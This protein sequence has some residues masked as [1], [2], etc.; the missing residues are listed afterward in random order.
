MLFQLW[1]NLLNNALKYSAKKEFPEIEIG[2][3]QKNGREV[4]YVSD[5]GVGIEEKYFE[6]IFESFT[7]VAGKGYK[8]S[9]IGLA[10]VKKIIDKHEG[11]IWVESTLKQGTTFYFYTLPGE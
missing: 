7:R 3:A 4:Y 9:G 1:S 11:G 10:I 6:H 5:N 2:T 8:G